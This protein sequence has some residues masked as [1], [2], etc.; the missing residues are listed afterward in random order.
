MASVK[1]SVAMCTYNGELF[2]QEQLDSILIQEVLPDELVVCDDGSTDQTIDLLERFAKAAPF[3]VSIFKNNQQ[4]LG[5]TKNF[6]KA[7]SLCS[8]EVIVLSDQDDV[9][10][11]NKT[12]MLKRAI[13]GGAGLAFSNAILVNNDL[14]P[15]GYSLFD[16][17]NL[18]KIEIELINDNR[19][20]E[21]LLR[22]NIVTG[23][24]L[25]FSSKYSKLIMP[26]SRNWVHDA[27]IALLIASIGSVHVIHEPLIKYRQH[28]NN[29][30][31]A[32]KVG[33]YKKILKRLSFTNDYFSKNYLCMVDFIKFIRENGI[34][35]S[36]DLLDL[37]KSRL[38]FDQSRLCLF[39]QFSMNQLFR[40]L[41]DGN[42][43]QFANG[44]TTF[45]I[46]FFMSIKNK[47][48]QR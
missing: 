41:I 18:S 24:T 5:S 10:M 13:D 42:Y 40:Q 19:L 33:Q 11:P 27:W 28:S 1:I 4:P 47:L 32:V 15:L 31:G 23:A 8:G 12:Y 6:E 29:Q 38:S 3:K 21:V 36:A 17:F 30:I 25:A 35:V 26:I 44:Y 37:I 20:I 34:N 43:H 2:L 16:F 46:D 7:I 22:R 48:F 9:W 45:A 14:E 39:K